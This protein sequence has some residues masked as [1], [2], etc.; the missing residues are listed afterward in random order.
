[1]ASQ[2]PRYSPAT[3]GTMN[4]RLTLIVVNQPMQP[5]PYMSTLSRATRCGFS[6]TVA[7]VR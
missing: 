3:S 5:I 6:S 4:Q 7:L 1:M 2:L